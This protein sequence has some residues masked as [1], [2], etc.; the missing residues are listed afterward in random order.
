MMITAM[1]II[2]NVIIVIRNEFKIQ[3]PYNRSMG[4]VKYKNK[5]DT[6]NNRVKWNRLKIIQKMS[7]RHSWKA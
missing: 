5:C 4:R 3:R 7:D 1:M 6:N 2:M